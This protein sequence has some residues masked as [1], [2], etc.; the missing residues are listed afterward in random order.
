MGGLLSSCTPPLAPLPEILVPPGQAPDDGALPF[1]LDVMGI[2]LDDVL[3]P[4]SVQSGDATATS[5]TIW[6]HSAD[7]NVPVFLRVWREDKDGSAFDVV[8]EEIQP[9]DAGNLKTTLSTLS[10]GVKYKYA[11]VTSDDDKRSI[12]G[13][14][15]M[16]YEDTQLWPHKIAAATCTNFRN[17]PYR[18]LEKTPEVSG[19]DLFVHLGDMSNNDGAV[20]LADYRQMWQQTLADPGYKATLAESSMII[21]WDDHEITNNL[22]P[23]TVAPE[24]MSNAINSFFE[25]LPIVPGENNRLWRSHQWGD[26]AEFITLDCR[27]ERKPSTRD[28]DDIYLSREQ[29]DFSK[30]RLKESTAVLKVVLNSV[31]IT[32]MPG[33]LWGLEGDRWQGYEQQR[34]EILNF[35]VDENIE[36]VVFLSGDFH[37]GFV[38]K[39]EKEG[40]RSNIYEVAVEPTANANNPLGI[41]V[42]LDPGEYRHQVFPDDQFLYGCGKKRGDIHHLQPIF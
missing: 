6:G 26:T 41:L 14:F 21:A 1:D 27:T 19:F 39:V 10:A 33:P 16:P 9:D 24:L 8:H 2:L 37:V 40:A 20:S 29:L 36:N 30:T 4:L 12:V 35:I 15:R 42:E 17:Q 28:D 23:E 18:V 5:V 32:L 13:Q 25:H 11:F 3:F 31:P 38:A 34:E 7:T 22:D